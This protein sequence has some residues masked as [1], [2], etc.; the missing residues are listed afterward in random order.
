MGLWDEFKQN[1]SDAADAAVETW[2]EVSADPAGALAAAEASVEQTVSAVVDEVKQDWQQAEKT[3]EN[4][5]SAAEQEASDVVQAATAA[6]SATVDEV[7]QAAA[8]VKESYDNTVQEL[9]ETWNKS[10]KREVGIGCLQMIG[11]ATESFSGGVTA[12]GGIAASGGLGTIPAIAGGSYL[13]FDG[14]SNFTGGLSRVYNGLHGLNASDGGDTFNYMKNGYIKTGHTLGIGDD[15]WYNGQ[16]VY[17]MTQLGIG[18]FSTSKG[19]GDLPQNYN[20]F[21]SWLGQEAVEHGAQT[22]KSIS[23]SLGKI[24]IENWT[25][26]G[27][28]VDRLTLKP[29]QL[30]GGVAVTSVDILNGNETVKS[31]TG[32]AQRVLHGEA[33]PTAQ[34]SPMSVLDAAIADWAAAN[35]QIEAQLDAGRAPQPQGVSVNR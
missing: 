2:N 30:A 34:P 20:K 14:I 28:L 6:V 5:V 21:S 7:T 3:V 9:H 18:I 4:A 17:D 35:R 12:I 31:I 8:T 23:A 22:W 13:I 24:D 16:N 26:G 15:K 29:L 10:N 27:L 33:A 19:I 32:V 1:I 11:G 25:Q